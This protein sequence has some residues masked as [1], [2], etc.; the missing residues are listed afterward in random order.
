MSDCLDSLLRYAS[1]RSECPPD[2]DRIKLT[3]LS[4][5][6]DRHKR[7][8]HQRSQTRPVAGS[9]DLPYKWID[10]QV[11]QQPMG[12]FSILIVYP[13]ITRCQPLT[14]PLW[15]RDYTYDFPH[16]RQMLHHWA[17]FSAL[18]WGAG[19]PY[20]AWVCLEFTV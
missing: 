5:G 14:F 9:V 18:F 4:S 6:L 7:G 3:R 2:M 17:P 15:F 12:S 1:T 8:Q 19:S 16:V 11:H 13:L 10:S 20:M